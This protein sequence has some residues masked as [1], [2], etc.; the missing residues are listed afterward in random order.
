M[1]WAGKPGGAATHAELRICPLPIAQAATDAVALLEFW[2][3]WDA[4][5][6]PE[7]GGLLDQPAGFVDA[8]GRIRR[9]LDAAAAEERE[10]ER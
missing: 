2:P 4:N 6:M 3:H 10:K 8:M 7:A 1:R 9:Q 5:R